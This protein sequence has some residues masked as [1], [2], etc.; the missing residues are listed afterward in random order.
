MAPV[1][2]KPI[3][4]TTIMDVSGKEI[5]IYVNKNNGKYYISS[6][7][8]IAP[9]FYKNG[10]LKNYTTQG[11]G[12]HSGQMT[13]IQGQGDINYT[14]NIYQLKNSEYI[15]IDPS[16]LPIYSPLVYHNKNNGSVFVIN[17]YGKNSQEY[18][19]SNINFR[20]EYSDNKNKIILTDIISTSIHTVTEDS[21]LLS[22]RLILD[23]SKLPFFDLSQYSRKEISH[24]IYGYLVNPN[25]APS[26]IWLKSKKIIKNEKYH[27]NYRIEKYSSSFDNSLYDIP[28]LCSNPQKIVL[29]CGLDN[30][31]V[32]SLCSDGNNNL[33][34]L[35]GSKSKI[36]L[37]YPNKNKG[38]IEFSQTESDVKMTNLYQ[39]KKG[40]YT[41]KLIGDNYKVKP[42]YRSY[43]LTVSKGNKT[44]F[45]QY[46][47]DNVYDINYDR[48]KFK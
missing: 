37:K 19:G 8:Y 25:Y 35:Y 12:S 23:Y 14:F 11:L 47:S 22:R 30:G 13:R 36:E 5:D 7:Q 10:I 18:G 34:Y 2:A 40:P 1:S 17:A 44:I 26:Y 15:P 32:I 3:Y 20:Y 46:C 6:P 39:F 27:H 33:E 4:S 41:Y 42:T 48:N 16:Y 29:S 21:I 45:N 9:Q 43:K 28:Q 31:K 24:F 38:K